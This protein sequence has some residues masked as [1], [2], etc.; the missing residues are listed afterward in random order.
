[1]DSSKLTF[2]HYAKNGLVED[3]V[4]SSENLVRVD[5]AEM[6][7]MGIGF[8]QV[9]FTYRDA[10]LK[11][12][13]S[14]DVMTTINAWTKTAMAG[15][16]AGPSGITFHH[17]T[18][19]AIGMT[20]EVKYDGL[21]SVSAVELWKGQEPYRMEVSF[22]CVEKPMRAFNVSAETFTVIKTCLKRDIG[23]DITMRDG[24]PAQPDN[25][26]I[27]PN[28]SL[29][30]DIVGSLFGA[31]KTNTMH[32]EFAIWSDNLD[33]IIDTRV[34]EV[35]KTQGQVAVQNYETWVKGEI[36]AGRLQG[37]MPDRVV[38]VDDGQVRD[39]AVQSSI[40]HGLTM[41]P[42]NIR[43]ASGGLVPDAP[44]APPTRYIRDDKEPEFPSAIDRMRKQA[45]AQANTVRELLVDLI[46]HSTHVREALQLRLKKAEEED[47]ADACESVEMLG[48]NESFWTHELEKHDMMVID[49][50]R[51]LQV[52]P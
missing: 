50:R 20:A 37:K 7:S 10:S 12:L 19:D 39:P 15:I 9:E 11:Y 6:A 47:A 44:P 45:Q 51:L 17:T 40:A 34:S 36:A 22:A 21:V 33:K 30:A 49:A 38:V 52:I 32:R 25:A 31:D 13:V 14:A 42:R 8:H 5:A 2:T 18:R 23:M 1:M 28:Y 24:R 35:M 4:V 26:R 29:F 27:N 3:A 16:P 46:S 43:F 48:A 41:F